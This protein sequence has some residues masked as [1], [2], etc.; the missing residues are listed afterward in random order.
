MSSLR[1]FLA[2]ISEQIFYYLALLLGFLVWAY[3]GSLYLT[4]SVFIILVLLAWYL[5]SKIE[6]KSK[7]DKKPNK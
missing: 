5:S 1:Q 7:N 6:G 3:S 4:I 2:S